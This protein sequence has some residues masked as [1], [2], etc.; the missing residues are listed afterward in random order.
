MWSSTSSSVTCLYR[1]ALGHGQKHCTDITVHCVC[2]TDKTQLN[3]SPLRHQPLETYCNVR[4][5][6]GG[7]TIIVAS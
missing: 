2:S 1:V 5:T 6:E 7:Y 3:G 4:V